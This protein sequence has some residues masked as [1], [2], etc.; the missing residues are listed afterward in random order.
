MHEN[1][2]CSQRRDVLTIRSEMRGEAFPVIGSHWDSYFFGTKKIDCMPLRWK[3]GIFSSSLPSGIFVFLLHLHMNS[4][5]SPFWLN[6][7][8]ERRETVTIP[9]AWKRGMRVVTDVP[10]SLRW[11][12][13]RMTFSRKKTAALSFLLSVRGVSGQIWT[14]SLFWESRSWVC[15][16]RSHNRIT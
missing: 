7:S 2:S 9:V 15:F 16:A 14:P 10:F 6:Q 12:G 11:I 13:R 8:F 5:M 3:K 4:C 1:S